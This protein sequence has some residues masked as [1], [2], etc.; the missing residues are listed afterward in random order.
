M[1]G[2][3]SRYFSSGPG[4]PRFRRATDV[5]MLVPASVGLVLL[6]VAYPPSLLERSLTS[7]LATLPSWLDPV[8]AFLYDLLGLWAI[9]LVVTAVVCRRYTVALEALGALALA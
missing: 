2:L 6:V 9:A 5:L 8:W 1:T 7:F 4:Q 3:G